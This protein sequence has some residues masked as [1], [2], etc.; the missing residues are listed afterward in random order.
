V[1]GAL[2]VVMRSVCVGVG[3]GGW[4][5]GVGDGVGVGVVSFGGQQLADCKAET[6]TR[7]M[8]GCA[9]SSLMPNVPPFHKL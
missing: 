2:C 1:G 5:E 7:C 6:G 4:G 3:G 8:P 9:S